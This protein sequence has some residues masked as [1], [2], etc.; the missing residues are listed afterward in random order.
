MK[1]LFKKITSLLLVVG[2][3]A[4]LSYYA[5]ANAGPWSG[6]KSPDRT[7]RITMGKADTINLSGPVADVLVA[8]PAIA[9]VG[10]L[11]S[12]KL[13]VVGRAVGDTNILVFND[14]GSQISNIAVHVRVDQDTLRAVMKEFF[15][16][17][18]IAVRTVNED[19]VLTGKVANPSIA[20]QVM[21]LAG[22]FVVDDGQTVVD[23]MTVAG[24]QQ[25]LLQVKVVEANRSVLR[26]LG[27]DADYKFSG[28]TDTSGF[29]F[30]TAGST[31]LTATPFGVGSIIFDDNQGFG[32]LQ[33]SLQALEQDG[34]VNT[35]AEPNLTAISGETAGF[36]AGGEFPVPS[37]LDQNGNIVID[38]KSFGVSLN[39]R[40]IVMSEDRI[41]MQ[42]STEVSSL[43]PQDGIVLAGVSI[44]GLQVRRAETTVEMGSGGSLMI[45]GLI[46]SDT[47]N[48]LNGVPGIQE[49]PVL[50]ELFKS[51][52][53]ARDE[54]ELLII[55]T[56]ILV[57]SYGEAQA[58]LVVENSMT[59]LTRQFVANLREVYGENVPVNLDTSSAFGYLV[60]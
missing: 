4:S 9:D 16:K 11:R 60:D 6:D 19:I 42:L 53:F 45:A 26:E 50:G 25:V 36:L 18:D 5:P 52:S 40:P 10:A 51:Q 29:E 17:E 28:L 31:G 41:S 13:Y 33:I 49:L 59:P 47:T 2:V 23:L 35:L 21:D 55:V 7:V 24:A 57:E 54:T 43:A 44:P 30:G 32:P 48:A 20:S 56:A 34:F 37:G 8:N 27:L 3:F 12:N 38:F 46:Q 14:K 39:F 1:C 22:R 58:E 15:P